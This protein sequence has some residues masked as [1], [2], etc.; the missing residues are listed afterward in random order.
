MAVEAVQHVKR[1]RGGAQGHLMRASDGH[2]Y[3]VKFQNN[4]QHLRV[5]ANE[6]L[7]TKLGELLGLPVPQ[8]E[9]VNVD[10]W[11]IEHTPELRIE[12]VHG[13][14]SCV[15]GLQCGSRYVVPPAEGV[16]YDYLPENLL[17][18]VRNLEAFAG[19][20]ILDK[21]TCNADGRQAAFWKKSRERKFTVSF[22]DQG[23]CFNAGEWTFPDSPLRGVYARNDVYR[24]ITGWNSFEPW[25]SRL[26]ELD[27]QK[28][29]R[30]AET[31]PPAWYGD[32]CDMERLIEQLLKRRNRVP[33]L[34]LNFRN[35]SRQPFPNW[36]ER[37]N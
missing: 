12:L 33:E 4:P 9:V 19:A 22:I 8:V 1:M 37:V 32:T 36:A 14:I 16:V 20:L 31:V 29:W 2:Y 5:L 26:Q 28:L 11:L 34:I 35:S 6:L 15:P 18:R 24:G 25:L 30:V 23:Y 10:S 3:V 13:V 7:A 21:W 17:E 27:E